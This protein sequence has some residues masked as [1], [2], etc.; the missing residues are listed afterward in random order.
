MAKSNSLNVFAVRSGLSFVLATGLAGIAKAQGLT[1][2]PDVSVDASGTQ[3]ADGSAA[4]G[5]RSQNTATAGPWGSLPLQDTPYSINVVPQA[6]I[7]NV[8]A[9]QPDQILRMN[10]VVQIQQPTSF[11]G[12]ATFNIR[13]FN[14]VNFEEDGLRDSNGWGIA[15]EEYQSVEVLSGLSGFLYGP[16]NVG[17]LINFVSKTPTPTPF[18]SVTVGDAGVSN[19]GYGNYYVHGDFGGPIDK[20]GLFAYRLNLVSQNGDQG[21]DFTAQRRNL[22]SGVLDWHVY[23]RLTIEAMATAYDYK[24]NGLPASWST[25]S[26][27]TS[28]PAAPSAD[29]LWSEPWSYQAV[30]TD[31]V[32]VKIKWDLTDIFSFRSAFRYATYTDQNQEIVNTIQTN[33]TYTQSDQARAFRRLANYDG[34]AFMD[35]RF[36]TLALEHKMT[37]GFYGDS[38]VFQEHP[39]EQASANVTGQ[40]N[41]LSPIYAAQPLIIAGTKPLYKDQSTFNKNYVLG[42]IIKINDYFTVIAGANYAD[43]GLSTFATNGTLSARYDKSVPT[44]TASLLF[45][46]VSWLTTYGSYIESLEQG[47]IVPSTGAIV[48][49]N[50]GQILAPVV[51]RQYEI[52]AKA[53]VGGMLL[54]AALF[55]IDK[56]NQFAS[57]NGNG[58]STDVQDGREVHKGG[59]LT[60]TG[61][62]FDDLTIVGGLTFFNSEVT[63]ASSTSLNGKRPMNVADQMVKVYAEYNIPFIPGLTLTGGAYYTGSFYADAANSKPLPAVLIGDVGARYVTKINNLPLTIRLNITNVADKSYWQSA[64]FVGDPRRIAFSFQTTF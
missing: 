39:D 13:G 26:K 37:F 9:T 41:L 49:T 5:Y 24:Q 50:A 45:K 60:A 4:A 18:A 2:V 3:P 55:Q 10:P 23:D 54:T 25:A 44:P 8:Q 19:D 43:I 33:N 61:K 62:V 11:N 36:D 1:P 29:Q 57:N 53:T 35:A 17:G 42:D 51:D 27:V 16:A 20:N 48:F 30:E 7:E 34:Y 56:A 21:P 46:P 22:V 31:K 6:L 38:S 12:R 64:N 32:G 15:M 28:Y 14:I 47:T 52:G 63:Q 59:E 58:T 40:F